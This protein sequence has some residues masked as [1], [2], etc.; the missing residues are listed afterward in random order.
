MQ[1][2]AK[3]EHFINQ[4]YFRNRYAHCL[5]LFF[6]F[7]PP[8]HPLSVLLTAQDT[9]MGNVYAEFEVLTKLEICATSG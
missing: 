8:Q 2:N 1:S 7:Y 4:K 5:V 3:R 6:L 9:Q